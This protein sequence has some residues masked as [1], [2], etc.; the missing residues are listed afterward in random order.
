MKRCWCSTALKASIQRHDAAGMSELQKGRVSTNSTYSCS[1]YV[2]KTNIIIHFCT[3]VVC[4]LRRARMLEHPAEGI[5][6]LRS[7]AQLFLSP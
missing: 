3:F 1:V 5:H 7:L 6:H 4:S 2:T